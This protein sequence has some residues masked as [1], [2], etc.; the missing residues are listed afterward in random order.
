MLRLHVIKEVMQLRVENQKLR[1]TI[2][3]SI[4]L[5]LIVGF[6]SLAQVGKFKSFTILHAMIPSR[7]KVPKKVIF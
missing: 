4:E 3:T 5:T 2:S 1:N 6:N 7:H